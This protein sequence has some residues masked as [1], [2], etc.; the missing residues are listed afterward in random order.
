MSWFSLS[1]GAARPA[2]SCV[3]AQR[4]PLLTAFLTLALLGSPALALPALQ[5]AIGV[6]RQAAPQLETFVLHGTLPLP[7]RLYLPGNPTGRFLLRDGDG[8]T[9]PAQTNVV[10]RY[11]L[12]TDGADVIELVSMV[13]R[14]DNVP[15]G[16]QLSFDVLHIPGADHGSTRPTVAVSRLIR[17]PGGITLRTRDVFGN[18]YKAE[19][20]RDLR[21]S[22]SELRT[23]KTGRVASQFRT[24]ENMLPVAPVSGPSGTLPHLMGV[25]SYVTVWD[26]KDI[27]SLDLRVHNGHEG[28]MQGD[29]QDDPM[30]T[31]FF[32]GLTLDVPEGWKVLSAFSDP[33][34]AAAVSEQSRVLVPLVKP[35]PNNK[36]HA[37]HQQSQFHRR[38]I[39]CKEG[40][41]QLALS[42]LREEGLA[43]CKDG[44]NT[45]GN[46]YY[47][48]WNPHTSRYFTTNMPLPNLD[49]LES[50]ADSR[51]EMNGLLY[52]LRASLESGNPG[53]WP[54]VSSNLGWAHPYGYE[55]GGA[56][57]GSGIFFVEGV[58]TAWSGSSD[59]YRYY[60]LTHRMYTE[61]HPTALYQGNGDAFHLERW[62]KTGPNGPYLPVYI[63]MIP[64]LILG[65]P[66]GF[67]NAPDLHTNAVE[68]QGRAPAYL[69]E[70]ETFMHVDG[71]HLIRYT[72]AAK[73]LAWLGNDSL[74]KDDL[75]MQAELARASYSVLPQTAGD[76]G[77]S[78]G[79]FVDKQYAEQY[80]HQGLWLDREQG[81][82]VNTVAAAYSMAHP[83]WRSQVR[84]WFDDVVD[85]MQLGQTNCIGS[86]M[87]YPSDN[88]LNGQYRLLQ[89]ISECIIQNALWGVRT[90]VYDNAAPVRAA[91]VDQILIKST[92]AMISDLVWEPGAP[93]PHFY[94]A[95]GP[96]DTTTPSF[97]NYVPA[98]GY[99]SYDGYQIWNMMVFGY[100][101]TGDARFLNRATDASGGVLTPQSMGMD[102]YHGDLETRA[103]MIGFLQTVLGL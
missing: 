13:T 86:I 77:I 88:H 22:S 63:W 58:K 20:M 69:R 34:L 54:V 82:M 33:T 16:T 21:S 29:A 61:R 10:S 47:S 43:F 103:G 90:T 102:L 46:R 93:N 42:I 40:S 4:R 92:Y 71:A 89:S 59:G 36:L 70:L 79:L 94:T 23:L 12:S 81:W 3:A 37:M 91:Q 62:V 38:L 95:L 72:R 55:H 9:Y 52:G 7:P 25:H 60:Q 35:L 96:W 24:H 84:P 19:L 53:P 2:C 51:N 101:L 31:L 85:L 65:D 68:A 17:Q 5:N 73:T 76:V 15:P 67:L 18:P 99:A 97:C 48:W 74:A 30:G 83:V 41:E 8:N 78:P 66:H 57:G 44:Y 27:V 64:W 26:R 80:P 39:L 98:D 1:L 11:P 14:P 56:P 28:R 45:Q 75:M 49:Y 6:L 87:S 50:E 32:D 100:K